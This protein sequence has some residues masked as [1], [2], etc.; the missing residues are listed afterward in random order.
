MIADKCRKINKIKNQSVIKD[1]HFTYTA[2]NNI[3]KNDFIGCVEKLPI[4]TTVGIVFP[5]N[6]K[7]IKVIKSKNEEIRRK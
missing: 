6:E 1:L 4:M 7:S 5:K 3:P 2:S